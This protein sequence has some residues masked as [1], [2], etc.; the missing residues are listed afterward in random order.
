M[1]LP[2]D[3][4][5][6][7]ALFIFNSDN[8]NRGPKC[9]CRWHRKNI[10]AFMYTCKYIYNILLY[11]APLWEYFS[12]ENL[13]SRPIRVNDP[14]SSFV[15]IFRNHNDRYGYYLYY[16]PKCTAISIY[17][18]TR[19]TIPEGTLSQMLSQITYLRIF[20]SSD[21][22]KGIQKYINKMHNLRTLHICG[23]SD[24]KMNI[25]WKF[26][27]LETLK[28]C[29]YSPVNCYHFR[30]LTNL[31][32]LIAPQCVTLTHETLQLMPKLTHIEINYFTEMYIFFNHPSLQYIT[33]TSYGS[34]LRIRQTYYTFSI[35]DIYAGVTDKEVIQ[36]IPN[37]RSIQINKCIWFSDPKY[38][39]VDILPIEGNEEEA[40]DDNV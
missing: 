28:I 32:K 39:P 1:P 8:A 23:N 26:P 4:I 22:C 40:E 10:L 17:N 5:Q 37:I 24:L 14:R 29:D 18:S 35:C 25:N 31:R 2:K 33:F 21:N 13:H 16:F 9:K 27:H 36:K 19:I 15:K 38:K 6:I 7:I 30:L 11:Y 12:M 20:I 3:I 34:Q